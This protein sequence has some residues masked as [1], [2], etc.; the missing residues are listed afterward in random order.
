MEYHL[1][2]KYRVIHE[3]IIEEEHIHLLKKDQK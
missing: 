2:Q 3:I 1:H